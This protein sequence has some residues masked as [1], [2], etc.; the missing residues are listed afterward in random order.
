M[1]L[2]CGTPGGSVDIDATRVREHD[3]GR[4]NGLW[5][6]A[7]REKCLWIAPRYTRA[8]DGQAAGGPGR[9]AGG[10]RQGQGGPRDR[11]LRAVRLACGDLAGGPPPTSA[12]SGQ[13]PQVWRA[14]EGPE[15]TGGLRDAAPS[16]A[17][18]P[19]LAGGRGLRRLENPWSQEQHAKSCWAAAHRHTQRPGWARRA[20]WHA[21]CAGP[22]RRALWHAQCAGPARRTLRYAERLGPAVR[23]AAA[24]SSVGGRQIQGFDGGLE[25]GGCFLIL[26]RVGC[27]LNLARQDAGGRG[28]VVR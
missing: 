1:S 27:F 21:Q 8:A 25:G 17:R 6:T 22:A 16:E 15:G 4:T 7:R 9:G 14:P 3:R 24:A 19:S 2:L 12:H 23:T 13:A 26:V 20:L 28:L 11:P 10:W 5:I 18:L